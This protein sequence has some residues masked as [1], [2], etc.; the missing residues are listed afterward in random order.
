MTQSINIYSK[1]S[2]HSGTKSFS[3]YDLSGDEICHNNFV[4]VIII[5]AV[6]MIRYSSKGS[7]DI[8]LSAHSHWETAIGQEKSKV[9]LFTISN[10]SDALSPGSNSIVVFRC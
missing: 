1:T 9:T 5:I 3:I 6:I 7:F 2:S 8:H 4:V 10:F